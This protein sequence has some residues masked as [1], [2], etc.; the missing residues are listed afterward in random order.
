MHF[1]PTILTMTMKKPKTFCDEME[2][3][4]QLKLGKLTDGFSLDCIDNFINC[5]NHAIV[6]LSRG[7][8]DNDWCRY[9]LYLCVKEQLK[10]PSFK[11]VMILTEDKNT[12]FKVFI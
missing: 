11:I 7:Y 9:A 6:I 10:D 3:K 5:S 1:S 2:R 8:L 12:L 4:Y